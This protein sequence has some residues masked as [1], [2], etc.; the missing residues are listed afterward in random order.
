MGERVRSVYTSSVGGNR[1]ANRHSVKMSTQQAVSELVE[2][3]SEF[4]ER[5]NTGKTGPISRRLHNH[6]YVKHIDSIY[7]VRQSCANI[8]AGDVWRAVC[9]LLPP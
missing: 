5:L 4:E 2:V 1:A 9:R 8:P 3:V 7:I 6:N